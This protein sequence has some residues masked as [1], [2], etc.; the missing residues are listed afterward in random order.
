M[1][2][3]TLVLF[4]HIADLWCYVGYLLLLI[5]HYPMITS[6]G[7]IID[8][9]LKPVCL[10][11]TVKTAFTCKNLYFEKSGKIGSYILRYLLAI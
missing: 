5:D 11:S 10:D 8:H 6:S 7:T 3:V 9:P 2:S 1:P 4:V